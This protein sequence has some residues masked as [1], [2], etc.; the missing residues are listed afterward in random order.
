MER[1]FFQHDMFASPKHMVTEEQILIEI[2]KIQNSRNVLKKRMFL[3][4]G[5]GGGRHV[6]Q[7]F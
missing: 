1:A 6:F 2:D 4:K 5:S 7:H 3:E